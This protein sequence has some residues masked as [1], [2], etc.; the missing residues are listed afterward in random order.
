MTVFVAGLIATLQSV[1]TLEIPH[2]GRGRVELQVQTPAELPP[3]EAGGPRGKTKVRY[4]PSL[5]CGTCAEADHRQKVT[6]IAIRLCPVDCLKGQPGFQGDDLQQD[7]GRAGWTTSVLLPV[8]EGLYTDPNHPG[9]FG[10]GEAG[11]FPEGAYSGG[12]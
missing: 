4:A 7:C 3:D 12:P 11:L 2:S 10:L 5:I 9:E 8:L 1:H 6:Q